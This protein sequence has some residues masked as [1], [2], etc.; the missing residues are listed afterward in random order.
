M[1]IQ[2]G[3]GGMKTTVLRQPNSEEIL[4]TGDKVLPFDETVVN[5][6]GRR[7]FQ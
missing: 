5:R 2:E 7:G 6:V 3:P 1:T 4:L